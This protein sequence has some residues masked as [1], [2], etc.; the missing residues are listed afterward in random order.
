M[1]AVKKH[2]LYL[3]HQGFACDIKF[4]QIFLHN[5]VSGIGAW[6][7]C[8]IFYVMNVILISQEILEEQDHADYLTL[9]ITMCYMIIWLIADVCGFNEVTSHVFMPYL[10][11][12]LA[13][14]MPLYNTWDDRN[15]ITHISVGLTI[16]TAFLIVVKIAVNLGRWCDRRQPKVIEDDFEG[17]AVEYPEPAYD[18]EKEHDNSQVGLVHY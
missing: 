13:F 6:L 4:M 7:S 2:G 18:Y 14:V 9:G 10:V 16:G 8:I 12:L 3:H 5:A 15:T 11:Y 1:Y 17:G